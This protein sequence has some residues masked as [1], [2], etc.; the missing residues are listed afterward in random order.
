[1]LTQRRLREVLH[2]EPLTGRF[3]WLISVGGVSKGSLAGRI[4]RE[5]YREIGVDGK[6]YRANR[7]AWLYMTGSWPAQQV[8]HENLNKSDDTWMNLREATYGQNQ[9]NTA[10]RSNNKLGVKGVSIEPRTGR[11]V[12][13]IRINGKS[14]HLGTFDTAVLAQAAYEMAAVKEVGE[15]ARSE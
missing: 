2:Y 6:L 3:T 9:M 14:R 1:M 15:F 12:A 8:D 13:R 10:V 5:G 11:Y 7:L 4:K